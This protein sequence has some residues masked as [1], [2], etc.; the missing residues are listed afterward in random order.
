MELDQPAI[1][2][3]GDFTINMGPQHPSTHGVLHLKVTLNGETIKNVEPHLGYIHRSIEKMSEAASLHRTSF[4]GERWASTS[5]RSRL[6]FLVSA[7]G[8]RSLTSSK[9]PAVP[10]L[11]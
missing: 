3:T 8:K 5:G 1:T 10:G 2:D 11:R 7:T 4:G 6:T 9:K